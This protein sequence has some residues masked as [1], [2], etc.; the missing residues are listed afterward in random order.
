[1]AKEDQKKKMKKNRWWFCFRATKYKTEQAE[2]VNT[3]SHGKIIPLQWLVGEWRSEKYGQESR[4]ET[5]CQARKRVMVAR[6]NDGHNAR[7]GTET[8]DE[9]GRGDLHSAGPIRRAAHAPDS[10]WVKTSQIPHL[11]RR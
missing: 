3:L 10:D 5:K 6:S 11:I 9:T 2:T 7:G 8:G 4:N 1:M